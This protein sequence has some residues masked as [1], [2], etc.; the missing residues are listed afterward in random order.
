MESLTVRPAEP[1]DWPTIVDFNCRIARETENKEL[2]PERI[3]AGVQRLLEE[4]TKGRYFVACDGSDIVGQ[5]M[6][7]WE[8]SDWRN[9]E[10]WWIQSVYVLEEYRRRGV[11]RRLY[12]RLHAEAQQDPGVVGLRLYV[13]SENARAQATYSGLGMDHTG[14]LVMEMLFEPDRK[15]ET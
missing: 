7:T 1:V 3:A 14:Y 6:H 10:I 9:G 5:I 13:E 12:D 8:W 2:H 4:P 11:F 15:P